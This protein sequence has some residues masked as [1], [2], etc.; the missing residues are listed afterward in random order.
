VTGDNN[1]S[2]ESTNR[3]IAA[4]RSYFG[5]KTQLNSQLLSRKTEILICETLVKPIL[6]YA[7]ENWTAKKN[8][9]RRLSI[10]ESKI[11]CSVYG[12]ICEGG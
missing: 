12:P 2:E 7:A 6:T 9:E 8:D 11:L 4:N 1:I 3:H 10:F 5:L